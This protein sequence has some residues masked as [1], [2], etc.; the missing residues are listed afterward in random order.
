VIAFVILLMGTVGYVGHWFLRG[1][2]WS[3][4]EKW[5]Y[6]TRWWL[7]ANGA[8]L[9]IAGSGHVFNADEI[10]E[11]IGWAPGSPFQREVGFGD[12]AW[13]VVGLA[14]IK[15]RGSFR[16]AFVLGTA[17]FLWAAAGGH[18]YEM[19]VNDNTA[20]NNSG[21]MLYMDIVAPIVSVLVLWR[22]R[23]AERRAGAPASARLDRVP[24]RAVAD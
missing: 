13:G 16:E 15:V 6:A 1:R 24:G 7:G 20:P 2:A 9:L 11:S 3:T 10:A 22:L 21:M 23:V 12:I 14:A 19:V 8:L 5:E 4:R 17:I 18:I